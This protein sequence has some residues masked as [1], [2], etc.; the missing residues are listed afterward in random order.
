MKTKSHTSFVIRHLSLAVLLAALTLFVATPRAPA[1][2]NVTVSAADFQRL[3]YSAD[4]H[5]ELTLKPELEACL[6]VLLEM[7]RRNPNAEPAALVGVLTNA[8]QIY[9]TSEPY[10]IRTDGY[11]DEIL[12]AYLD[13]LRQV[14]AHTN[15]IP[16]YLTLLNVFMLGAA[17]Y[18]GDYSYIN[19]YTPMDLV[20]SAKQKLLSA[21]GKAL[22]RQGLVADCMA[23]A[24][25]NAAF[26][27]AMD[28]LLWPETGVWLGESPAKIIGDTNSPLHGNPT[29]TTL[30]AWS[31]NAN[32]SLTVY[33]DQLPNL[34][35]NEMQTMLD[36]IHTNL[37]V[38]A[39]INQSQPDYLAYL[40]NPAALDANAQLIAAVQ[41]YQPVKLASATAAVL[42]QSQLQSVN[43]NSAEAEKDFTAV[44]DIAIGIGSLCM[45]EPDLCGLEGV[46]SGGLD[47]FNL[48]SGGQSQQDVMATEIQNIQTMIGDLSTNM[49]YRFDRVD[50][51]LTTMFDTMN[52][53]FSEIS[54]TLYGLP[55]NRDTHRQR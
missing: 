16:A 12:A 39:Q 23:R 20:N 17:D 52:K 2:T 50:Q 37:V 25:G 22:K 4:L 44:A 14:P 26:A 42:V 43:T 9:R 45:P 35:T 31:T 1:Q 33:S 11:P 21:E 8:L 24:Q 36:T 15:F 46:V 27:S 5:A 34:F 3:V 29:M 51:S 18:A 53:Q 28:H 41:Q 55:G 49:N 7:Q 32:G 13:A 40:N 47:L 48:L 19:N 6:K 54:I 38:L 10:S 30:L